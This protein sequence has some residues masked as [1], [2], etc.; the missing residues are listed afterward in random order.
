MV[1]RAQELAELAARLK[2][3]KNVKEVFEGNPASDYRRLAKLCHPDLFSPGPQQDLAQQVFRL[4]TQWFERALVEPRIVCSPLHRYANLQP[5]AS[6]DLADVFLAQADGANYV[7]K[8]CRANRG[9]PLLVGEHRCLQLLARRSGD[10]R[11]RE[12]LP[13]PVES[14]VATGELAGRQ[15]NVFTHRAGFRTLDEVREK[16]TAGLDARHL[17][18][19]FKR[20]LVAAGFAQQCGIVHGALLPPHLLIHAENHGLQLVDWT[21]QVKIGQRLRFIPTKYRDWYPREVL[22]KQPATPATDLF[23]AAK[24]LLYAAG[25]DPASDQWPTAVPREMQQFVNTCLYPSPRMRPQ[26][27]WQLHAEFDEL[28]R[29]LFGSPKYQPLVLS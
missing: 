29:R 21:H 18:W 19:L 24:S 14:F 9:D 4:L 11:Y 25:G 3:A 23:L 7:L 26:N 10:R 1:H 20:M 22:N 13:S 28:L 12:Y 27:A 17:A 8:V 5:L 2:R 15:I 16:Y 6:G